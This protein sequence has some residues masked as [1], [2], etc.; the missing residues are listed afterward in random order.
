MVAQALNIN[1]DYGNS[2]VPLLIGEQEQ[3]IAELFEPTELHKI[4]DFWTITG[5]QN[6]MRKHM[7]EYD[8][9]NLKT[10]GKIIK[11]LRWRKNKRNGTTGY[12]LRLRIN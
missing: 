11:L 8:I 4:E 9:P 12:Y 5:I 1:K 6:E 7:K 10:L 2:M 3:L